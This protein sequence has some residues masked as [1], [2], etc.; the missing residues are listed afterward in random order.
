MRDL[1]FEADVTCAVDLQAAIARALAHLRFENTLWADL[2][3]AVRGNPGLAAL[4][5][6]GVFR[7]GRS[8]MFIRTLAKAHGLQATFSRDGTVMLSQPHVGERTGGRV[9]VRKR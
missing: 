6:T 4:P 9:S 1:A 8:D 5:V 2:V 7:V 3:T